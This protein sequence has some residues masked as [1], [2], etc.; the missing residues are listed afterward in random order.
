MMA[1]RS[2]ARGTCRNVYLAQ[3]V[4]FSVDS[5]VILVGNM[6]E[7]NVPVLRWDGTS[8]TDRGSGSRSTAARRRF[9]SRIVRNGR[10]NH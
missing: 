2:R 10:D 1:T 8:L 5:S 6:V 9:A 3:G 4:A 7:R